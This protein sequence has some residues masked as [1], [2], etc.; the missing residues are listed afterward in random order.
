MKKIFA[1]FTAAVAASAILPAV[2]V[3]TNRVTVTEFSRSSTVQGSLG[4]W[5][6]NAPINGDVLELTLRDGTSYPTYGIDEPMT[7]LNGQKIIIRCEP[8]LDGGPYHA[9]VGGA[10]KEGP[11]IDTFGGGNGAPSKAR[12]S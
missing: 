3:T 9:T 7:I 8:L 10:G 5:I 6:K 12:Y 2:A 4:W 1:L 11:V